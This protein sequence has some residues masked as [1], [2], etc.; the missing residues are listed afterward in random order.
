MNLLN[1]SS[2]SL[3]CKGRTWFIWDKHMSN[4]KIRLALYWAWAWVFNYLW[5]HSEWF[6][7]LAFFLLF[8]TV[9]GVIK[10]IALDRKPTSRRFFLGVV[11]KVLMLCVPLLI[12]LLSK[13]T[14][15]RNLEWFVSMLVGLLSVWEVYSIIQNIVIIRTQK[16]IEEYD[17]ITTVFKRLLWLLR[18]KIDK[19]M[20]KE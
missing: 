4:N 7:I 14:V 10:T 13:V 16:E 6:M 20:P 15:W 1:K 19:S 11:S 9:T 18:D 2:C 17:A 3:H 8:D 12:A 5:L